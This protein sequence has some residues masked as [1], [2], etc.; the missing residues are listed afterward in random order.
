MGLRAPAED[1]GDSFRQ[2]VSQLVNGAGTVLLVRSGEME[3]IL[4]TEGG[5]A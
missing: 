4:D 2:Q 5:A 3:D 1:E